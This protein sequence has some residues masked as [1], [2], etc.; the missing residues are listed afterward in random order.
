MR[1][2]ISITVS[3]DHRVCCPEWDIARTGENECTRFEITLAEELSTYSAYID[4]EKPDGEKFKTPRLNIEYN[5]IIYDLPS[6][7]LDVKGNLLVQLVLQNDEG[8]IWKSNVQKFYVSESVDATEAIVEKDD[9]VADIEKRVDGK[10]DKDIAGSK[11][12]K[13]T[14]S[15]FHYGC[16]G[17]II[18]RKTYADNTLRTARK[19]TC[20]RYGST[21][22]FTTISSTPNGR[23]FFTNEVPY[24]YSEDLYSFTKITFKDSAGSVIK[25]ISASGNTTPDLIDWYGCVTDWTTNP[26]I[27]DVLDYIITSDPIWMPQE[28]KIG[29]FY[30]VDIPND[31]ITENLTNEPTCIKIDANYDSGLRQNYV[32]WGD[33]G[34]LTTA[35]ADSCLKA[36]YKV[37]DN[38]LTLSL[39][40]NKRAGQGL[41]QK[42]VFKD[43]SN[44]HFPDRPDIGNVTVGE[45]YNVVAGKENKALFDYGFSSGKNNA[46][47]GRYS[48]TGGTRNTAAY[49]GIAFGNHN[50]VIG[51][52]GFAAGATNLIERG[53]SNGIALGS[54]N[55][56]SGK[57]NIAGGR[58]NNVSNLY[59]VAFGYGNKVKGKSSSA[60][61]YTN[62][63]NDD[64]EFAAGTGNTLSGENAVAIGRANQSYGKS[65][66]CIGYGNIVNKCICGTAIGNV[67]HVYANYAFTAGNNNTVNADA[68]GVIGL[69]LN[70]KI[71]SESGVYDNV[72]H[73][74]AGSNNTI[75]GGR[76]LI[77]GGQSNTALLHDS[78]VIGNNLKE[79]SKG[80]GKAIF[81][82][83]NAESGASIV[84]GAG[85]SNSTRKNVFEVF[86]DGAVKTPNARAYRTDGTDAKRLTTVEFVEGKIA[87]ALI[88]KS[89]NGTKYKLTVADDGTLS[90]AKVD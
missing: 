70:A 17:L 50:I 5:R 7:V 55:V 67:N 89:P 31:V 2:I 49:A 74:L 35:I 87:D 85:S 24:L 68:S 48:I 78:I 42:P 8:E 76:N 43:T 27:D 83:Y 10:L 11:G 33:D 13:L 53:G 69:N 60:L 6:A 73:L 16:Y 63:L 22:E 59:S 34:T 62:S 1:N 4:F 82:N 39:K 51:Q 14:E 29:A 90:T 9:F 88:L 40:K 47:L 28:D 45:G 64:N 77:M 36:N 20:E 54:E 23:A 32:D 71:S 58:A 72:G 57:N 3:A 37:G 30:Y 84:L 21:Q 79:T 81:G 41:E 26:T 19:I 52:S 66:T 38:Y 86:N 44:I 61:G 25:T 46:S 75:N 18:L 65:N 56:V 80:F 12:F 15:N